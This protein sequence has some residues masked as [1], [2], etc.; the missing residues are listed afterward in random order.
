MI[1]IVGHTGSGKS[2]V[3]NLLCRFYDVSAGAVRVDGID[4]RK[5]SIEAYRKHIGIVLQE[6]FL[7]FGTIADNVGYGEPGAR[8]A[9]IIQAAR[10]AHAHDFILKLPEGYDSLVGER[11]QS[12]SGG[13]RQ[14]IAIA[15]A[16]LVDPRILVLDEATSAVDTHTER[17]IQRALDNVVAGRTTIAI[18]HRLSTL[19][20]ADLLL[21]IKDGRLAE[22]G[23][24]SELLATGGEYARLHRAQA[25][26]AAQRE[27]D[28]TAVG[29]VKEPEPEVVPTPGLDAAGLVIE[30]DDAGNLW[31]R[32][33]GAGRSIGERERVLPRRA[34]PLTHPDGF[35]SLL[36]E[37]GHDRVCI[38]NLS[39]LAVASREALL[40]VLAQSEFLPKVTRI[41]RVVHEATRS[42][43]HVE[44]DRGS[45]TFVVDQED[46]IR[47]LE[48]GRH[49]ITDSFGMRYL[50]PTPENLDTASRRWLGRY[51]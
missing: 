9:Q 14:R 33:T 19:R 49:V 4:I 28:T 31:A 27:A 32:S 41:E 45:C 44:T 2:T 12:L 1:G 10:S 34:F 21:V 51:S 35:V 39:D 47:R 20:K 5:L 17:E 16:I 36:D 43:W 24:H 48:D 26:E 7:F 30:R 29:P 6:P 25:S 46:H 50:V 11:G 22:R 38:E 40:S 23:T 18:A 3:A 15:R 37:H 42:E 8:G 13:E